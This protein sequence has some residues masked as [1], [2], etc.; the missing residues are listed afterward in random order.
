MFLDTSDLRT[1]EI[2]LRLE[3]TNEAVPEKRWV[4]SYDFTIRL[5]SDDSEVGACNFRFGNTERTFFG[6]NIGYEVHAPYRGNHYAGKACLLLLKLARK[7]EM[8]YLYVTCN[9]DNHASR[10]TLEW[11]GG[12]FKTIVELPTDSDMYRKD[13][14]RQKCIYWFD[15]SK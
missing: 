4:P 13:G 9:P 11:A 5:A 14:E 10:R 2:Y 7:H 12:E 6:G 3:K 8:K 1:E 15:L